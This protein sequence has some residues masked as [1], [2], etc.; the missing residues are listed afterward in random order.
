MTKKRIGE[1]LIDRGLIS[2]ADRDKALLLQ[3]KGKKHRLIGHILVELKVLTYSSLLTALSEDMH[4]PRAE[5]LLA[6]RAALKS[7]LGL[8]TG[9]EPIIDKKVDKKSS[10]PA[11]SDKPSAKAPEKTK[12]ASIKNVTFQL[13]KI[14][15]PLI[16]LH[17]IR[18]LRESKGDIQQI[19]MMSL[20]M[21]KEEEFEEATL[22]I[23]EG[24]ASDTSSIHL[25]W[26]KIWALCA[27]KHMKKAN[28]QLSQI[29]ATLAQNPAF[30]SLS[31]YILIDSGN[32]TETIPILTKLT[33]LK[34]ADLNWYFWLAY[35]LAQTGHGSHATLNYQHYIKNIPSDNKY[36]RFARK[37][38][39]EL[40]G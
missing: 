25:K 21:L 33:G 11:A 1:F 34:D 27:Q 17:D 8:T 38:L 14:E 35:A 31:C 23:D 29:D 12:K 22:L 30:I 20:D 2:T 19:V 10:P 16:E 9:K 36:V 18:Y 28:E 40:A 39:Q 6:D 32:Y 3:K 4:I 13:S 15:L 24:L 37:Q 5:A 26:L 7:A